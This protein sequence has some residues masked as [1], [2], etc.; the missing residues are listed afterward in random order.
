MKPD[1]RL[2][3]AGIGMLPLAACS[4]LISLPGQGPRPDAFDLRGAALK[5]SAPGPKLNLQ[6]AVFE[7]IAANGLDTDRIAVRPS[8]R[9]IDYYANARW[10][11]RAPA[12]L[13]SLLQQSLN[14]TDRISAAR[15]GVLVAD[16]NLSSELD[17]FDAVIDG[18]GPPH[19]EI[20][21]R[22][23]LVRPGQGRVIAS[24]LISESETAAA[25]DIPSVVQA[26][27]TSLRRGLSD[28]VTFVLGE[29]QSLKA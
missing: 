4:S 27:E 17:A 19:I 2:I 26:F 15:V 24:K 3:L 10:T 21:W 6:L 12:L 7:P 25:T 23:R 22:L 20:E 13:Q 5:A 9:R 28:A 8:P 1:R 14:G 11:D 29:L 16:V 18:D